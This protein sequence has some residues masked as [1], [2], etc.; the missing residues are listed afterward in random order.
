MIN[1]FSS[2]E[3]AL[4]EAIAESESSEKI[5]SVTD[6]SLS[7]DSSFNSL[8][9]MSYFLKFM[10]GNYYSHLKPD[11][12]RFKSSKSKPNANTK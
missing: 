8:E 1:L 11:P 3:E 4:E 2:I 5:L 7:S 9:E 6:Q 10:P 12:D